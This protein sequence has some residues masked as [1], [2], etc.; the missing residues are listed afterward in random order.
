MVKIFYQDF[1][2][3][4]SRFSRFSDFRVKILVNLM[5]QAYLF[6]WI[7]I[8]ILKC[9]CSLYIFKN[10][11]A[12]KIYK[13]LSTIGKTIQDH[14]FRHIFLIVLPKLQNP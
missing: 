7:V 4:K 14:Q 10:N 1:I 8:E 12:E 2:I 6:I 13:S 9:Q 3:S 5:W 11:F